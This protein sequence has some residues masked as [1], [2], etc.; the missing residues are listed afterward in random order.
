M[1]TIT[2]LKITVLMSLLCQLA[3]GD[4]GALPGQGRVETRIREVAYDKAKIIELVGYLGYQTHIQLPAGENLVGMSEGAPGDIDIAS[5]ENDI[6]IRPKAA[7][8]DTN[9]DIKTT[10]HVYHIDYQARKNP[11]KDKRLITYS[12]TIL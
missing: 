8:A 4:A 5:D 10:K 1:K 2:N 6:W 7:I 9:I 11:P 3:S 12:L